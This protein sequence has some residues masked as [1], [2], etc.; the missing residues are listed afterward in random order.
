MVLVT[1]LLSVVL[2]ALIFPGDPTPRGGDFDLLVPWEVRAS[3]KMPFTMPAFKFCF[4]DNPG[5]KHVSVSFVQDTSRFWYKADISREQGAWQTGVRV[6]CAVGPEGDVRAP[7]PRTPSYS[8]AVLCHTPRKCRHLLVSVGQVGP[9]E[10]AV[11]EQEWP[12]AFRR[13][14]SHFRQPP[15]GIVAGD[16]CRL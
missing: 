13:A 14:G 7:L 16:N 12:R 10:G 6:L 1:V 8:R 4:A 3:N 11:E 9:R 5:D 15:D 2:P